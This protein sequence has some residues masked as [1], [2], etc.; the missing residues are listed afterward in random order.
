[1]VNAVDELTAAI[2]KV[3]GANL[4]GSMAIEMVCSAAET[5]LALMDSPATIEWCDHHGRPYEFCQMIRPPHEFYRLDADSCQPR[6]RAVGP[7]VVLWTK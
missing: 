5:F 4:M 7:E 6:V 2:T 3:R 1:V